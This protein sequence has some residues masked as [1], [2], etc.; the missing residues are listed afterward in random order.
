MGFDAEKLDA[1]YRRLAKR[2][3]FRIFTILKMPSAAFAGLRLDSI[4]DERC[5]TSL[6][7]GWRSQNPFKTMYWAAQGMA[8]ELAT[9]A[10]PF[11]ISQACE[12]GLRMFVIGT[13]A[14]FVKRAKGRITFTCEEVG[15]TRGAI[16]TALS[17]S[18]AVDC[19]LHS[20]GRDAS[21]DVV[22]EWKFKWNFRAR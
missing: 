2:G 17:S 1:E 12:G 21:G 3:R 7:G 20:V 15:K 9:G 11:A 19:E 18:G 6:A 22:S 8:A 13:E 5:I 16:E 4:D 10:A 14:R